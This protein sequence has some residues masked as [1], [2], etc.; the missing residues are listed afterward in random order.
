MT[1]GSQ[2]WA[3]STTVPAAWEFT[4]MMIAGPIKMTDKIAN[5]TGHGDQAISKRVPWLG[6]VL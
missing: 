3:R 4:H 1:A 5:W 2:G 6:A